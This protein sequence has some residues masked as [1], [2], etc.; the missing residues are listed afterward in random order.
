[1]K[2][3]LVEDDPCIASF[4]RRGLEVEGC[5][6]QWVANAQDA[7]QAMDEPPRLAILDLGL[8]DVDGL[9]LCRAWRRQQ[10]QLP[11]LILSARDSVES[12][13]AGLD[14]GADDYLTKPFEFEELTARLRAL[15][16]R[17]HSQSCADEDDSQCLRVGQLA[18]NHE[19]HEVKLGERQLDLTEREFL[20]LEYLMRHA[21]KVVAREQILNYAWDANSDVTDNAVD[22]YISYLRRKIEQDSPRMIHTVRGIG[23]KLKPATTH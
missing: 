10:A 19:T 2:V 16:R 23:F 9:S 6:V 14:A 17:Q 8:P 11:I 7:L 21:G 12:K 5:T 1:M 13:V 3:L 15:S 18:L 4:I 20:L 22:V